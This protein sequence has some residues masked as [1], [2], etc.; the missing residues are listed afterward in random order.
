MH[1]AYSIP[2]RFLVLLCL[3]LPT[4]SK[5]TAI[6][7]SDPPP[8]KFEIVN[9]QRPGQRDAA[10]RRVGFKID[11]DPTLADWLQAGAAV[12][13]MVFAWVQWR[14]AVKTWHM[15]KLESQL[16]HARMQ[17]ET[18]LRGSSTPLSKTALLLEKDANQ[19]DLLERVVLQICG[20]THDQRKLELVEE[21]V[22]KWF[23]LERKMGGT[24]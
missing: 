16:T 23:D 22:K 12:A 24:V 15:Q 2:I 11:N 20:D 19:Q 17:L 8:Q 6:E 18:L 14:I 5:E 21:L 1:Q 9:P 13:M 4:Y 3:V 7:P 10:D